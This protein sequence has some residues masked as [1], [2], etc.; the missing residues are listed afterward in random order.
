MATIEFNDKKVS[1]K[2]DTIRTVA[3]LIPSIKSNH[4]GKDEYLTELFINGEQVNS[5]NQ[6]LF[7]DKTLFSLGFLIVRISY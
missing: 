6:S 2:L 5:S 1:I 7:L 4:L 3:E